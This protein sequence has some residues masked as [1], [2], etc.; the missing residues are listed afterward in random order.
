MSDPADF[1]GSLGVDGH[2]LRVRVYYED[3]D[4]SG[5]VYHVSYLR[6]MERGRTEF[7]RAIGLQQG[8]MLAGGEDPLGFVVRRMTIDFLRPAV[9]DDV[10]VVETIPKAARGAAIILMQRV[11]RDDLV[12]AEAEVKIAAV[13][14]GRAR[15]LPADLRTRIA[16]FAATVGDAE[17]NA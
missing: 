7:L 10:I 13:A 8:G 15:R 14:H 4:F 12:L 16:A 6:F 5:A 17:P 1:G 11:L 2:R 9:M 3:T